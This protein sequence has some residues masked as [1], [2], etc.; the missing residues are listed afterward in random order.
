MKP[1]FALDL[2]F[3]VI[4]LLHR[5]AQGWSKVGEAALD[6]PDLVE[7]LAF[8]RSTALGLSPRGIATKVILPNTQILYTSV[9]APVAEPWARPERIAAALEGLTPYRLDEL[10]YDWSED[11]SGL[12]IAVLAKETLQEAETFARAHR[13]N[14]VSFVAVPEA[15]RFGGEPFFGTSRLS[16]SLLAKEDSVERDAEPVR[17]VARDMPAPLAVGFVPPAAEL[18]AAEPVALEPVAPK[19]ALPADLAQNAPADAPADAPAA[20]PDPVPLA[21]AVRE[22]TP[23]PAAKAVKDPNPLPVPDTPQNPAPSDPPKIEAAT[24]QPTPNA[25]AQPKPPADA[26]APIAQAPLADVPEAPM[27]LDVDLQEPEVPADNTR[28]Q[29]APNVPPVFA[30]RDDRLRVVGPASAE[31]APVPR[32]AVA[33]P[34]PT[35]SPLDRPR[36]ARPLQATT[37]QD[38]ARDAAN[39]AKARATRDRVSGATSVSAAKQRR[40]IILILS[41]VLVLLLAI[42]AMWSALSLGTNEAKNSIASPAPVVAQNDSPAPQSP[43]PFASA[44]ADSPKDTAPPSLEASAAAGQI[45]KGSD[46]APP[47]TAIL[48][49][50]PE[51]EVDTADVVAAA[52]D[53]ATQ[54]EIFLAS[55]DT[56]PVSL[57]PIALPAL[58]VGADTAPVLPSQPPPYVA[59]PAP[60]SPPTTATATPEGA[61]PPA[62]VLIIAGRPPNVPL[63]RPLDLIVGPPL[64]P[65]QSLP[66]AAPVEA[67]LAQDPSLAGKRPRARPADLVAVVAVPEASNSLAPDGRY[68][69]LRPQPRPANLTPSPA[70]AATSDAGMTLVASPKPKARPANLD[71]GIDDAVAVALNQDAAPA[72]PEAEAPAPTMPT[73][74][75]VAKQATVK[76]ALNANRVALLAVFGTPSSRYAMVRLA[77]GRVKKVQVG[78]TVEGGRIAGIAA[79][80][81]QYQKGSRVVTLALP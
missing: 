79:D 55:A 59:P 50:A 45:A 1:S 64:R 8:M 30:P 77:S 41:A 38:K 46:P 65:V 27:A 47:Q 52:P 70:T 12:K 67:V 72:Q 33:K 10:A 6:A 26:K 73:N 17:V 23:V 57:D 37:A 11:D 36:G 9:T 58:E 42:V 25:D 76:N 2:R 69:K 78:D 63:A 53:A 35:P 5:T 34:L 81:V 51:T 71:T 40:Y 61:T 24:A 68:A 43:P 29:P 15:G 21:D 32:P 18:V 75:S 4:A 56:P 28:T 7:A 22:N 80:S 66:S 3:S 62:G 19:P 14:P 60:Q 31:R 20:Q 13:F 39:L 49:P 54:D 74:A 16:P 44:T 48:E